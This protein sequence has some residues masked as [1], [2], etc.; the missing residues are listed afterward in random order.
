MVFP[1]GYQKMLDEKFFN[2]RVRG[3]KFSLKTLMKIGMQNSLLLF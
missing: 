1:S 2:A 3:T